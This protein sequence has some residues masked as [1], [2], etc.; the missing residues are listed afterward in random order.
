MDTTR[1]HS[2]P[3]GPRRSA[4]VVARRPSGLLYKQPGIIV[5]DRWFVVAGYRYPVTELTNLRMGR[6]SRHPLAVRA[7]VVSTIVLLGIGSAL[8]LTGD[9]TDL[10]A[11]SYLAIFSAALAPFLLVSVGE[12]LRPRPYELWADYFGITV[13]L[14][15]SDSEQQF[16]Q[17]ARA[18]LRA[19]EIA[20]L[21][22]AAELR[23]TEP[24]LS[25]RR[26]A[27]R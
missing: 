17:V 27:M 26:M 18:L 13:R 7:S 25:W 19:K 6:G 22:G 20:R 2:I 21:G 24:W 3:L 1:R 12:R 15:L 4:Q 8:G 14:F 10:P 11:G 23:D 9:P 16:G 5:T